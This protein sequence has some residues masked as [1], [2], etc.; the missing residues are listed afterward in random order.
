MKAL[1][2]FI[3]EDLKKKNRSVL[4]LSP[5]ERCMVISDAD[6][7]LKLLLDLYS[8][9][10]NSEEALSYALNP[11]T[12]VDILL[13]LYPHPAPITN[14]ALT[15]RMAETSEVMRVEEVLTVKANYPAYTYYGTMLDVARRALAMREE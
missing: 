3:V 7:P 10:C 14:F 15:M 4:E 6:A 8:V 11:E 9:S 12:P 13:D 2:A 1:T 5:D